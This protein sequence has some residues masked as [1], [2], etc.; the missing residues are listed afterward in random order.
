MNLIGFEW[1][2]IVRN[3]RLKQLFIVSMLL[4]P[5]MIYMHLANSSLQKETFL[6]KEFFLWAMFTLSA[7]FATFAFS[8]NAAF[9]EKQV[10]APLS[11]FKI[12][13]AKYRFFCI[14]AIVLF[15]LFLPSMFLGVKLMELLAAFLF[16]VGF[17]FFGLFL[18]SLSSY[19][20][21]NIKGSY[22]L[23]Y[24]GFDVGNYLS[25]ILVMAVAWGFTSL[26]YYLF[27]EIITLISMSLIGLVFILTNRIWL[28]II[29]KKFEKTK[30]R[31]LE[32]FREK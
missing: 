15:I 5:S 18:T 11:I 3:K 1:K 30:Y 27:N 25:P 7:N 14:V 9:I 20:P 10:I 2:L 29:G 8:I 31:R 16:A 21:F 28:G 12:L 23:N 13:Q 19:K 32:R 24:Q 22:F 4:L 17:G 6:L 26:L